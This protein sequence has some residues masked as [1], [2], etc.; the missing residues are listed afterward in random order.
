MQAFEYIGMIAIAVSVIIFL[1]RFNESK[2]A[3]GLS[4]A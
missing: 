3:V 4:L 1:T 2:V